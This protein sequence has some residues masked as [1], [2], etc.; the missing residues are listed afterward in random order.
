MGLRYI[1][2]LAPEDWA[3]LV[4]DLKQGPSPEQRKVVER[5][6]ENTRRRGI[7]KFVD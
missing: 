2:P 4:K 3:V 7:D 1:K 6:I 5:A